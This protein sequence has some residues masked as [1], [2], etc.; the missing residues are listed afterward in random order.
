MLESVLPGRIRARLP[1]GLP[2]ETQAAI[3]AALDKAAAGSCMEY[4]PRSGSLL[5]SWQPGP[6][7]DVAVLKVVEANMSPEAAKPAGSICS[8]MARMS[9]L[10]NGVNIPWPAMKTVKKGMLLSLGAALT[11]L[12]FKSERTHYLAGGVFVALLLRHTHVYRKRM[13]K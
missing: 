6:K 2:A 4:N 3:R 8:G 13:F 11:A 7:R 12:V 1:Q 10:A 5:V 9:E